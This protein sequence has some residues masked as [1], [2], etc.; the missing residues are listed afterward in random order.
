MSARRFFLDTGFGESRGVVMLAG[1]P[2]RLMIVRDAD[3]PI[4]ALGARS[5]ARVRSVDRAQG[6]AFM[7]LGEGP[8]AVIN[9]VSDIGPIREG[10]WAEIEIR[11]EAR[12]SKGGAARW[13]APGEGPIRLLASPPRLE[14]RLAALAKGA[15]VELGPAARDA[16]DAA[17]DE[18]MET[19]FPLVGGGSIAVETTRALVSVD[20]DVG[21]RSSGS[22]KSLTR[23]VNLAALAEAARILR[24][25]GLGGLVVIDLAGRG[26]DGGALLAA[27]RAAF[28]PDNPGVAIGPVSRFGT[29]ELIVPR[30]TRPT[31]EVLTGHNVDT[32]H[33]MALIRALEREAIADGG[34]RFEALAAVP[35]AEIAAPYVN[36]LSERFGARLTVRPEPGRQGYEVRRA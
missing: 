32:T 1:R 35:I 22:G 5:V 33:A 19:V 24:L 7:D 15:Q 25:K 10:G 26:H 28:G 13:L 34:G 21:A 31:L 36:R 12:A 20:V 11:A 29:L 9:L 27:A 14:E 23:A 6:L 18:A 17:Q 30:R 2:E 3:L 4:Q 16:A 8:D